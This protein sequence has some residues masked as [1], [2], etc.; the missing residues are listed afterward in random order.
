MEPALTLRT[1][2]R[3]PDTR[4]AAARLRILIA[5]DQ[6]EHLDM[7]ARALERSAY[8][9]RIELVRAEDGPSAL[10]LLDEAIDLAFFDIRMPGCS[11]LEA[12]AEMRKRPTVA[13]TP[14]VIVSSSSDPRD[15]EHAR[16]L[17]VTAYVE[18]G[19]YSLLRERIEAVLGHVLDGKPL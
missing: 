15:V 12:V 11:G 6:P 1:T 13:D 5:D 7:L 19:R 10:A 9:P 17:G 3:A 4:P 16:R 2:R 8:G 18:K 14:V